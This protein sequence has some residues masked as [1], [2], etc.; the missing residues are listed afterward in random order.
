MSSHK[1]S[2]QTS[3]DE[4]DVKVFTNHPTLYHEDGN[5]ILSCGNTLF[6]VHRSVVAKHSPVLKRMLD[7]APPLVLRGCQHLELQDSAEDFEVLLGVLYDG[8]RIDFPNITAFNYPRVSS[9]L[10]ASTKYQIER[11]RA[12]LIACIQ[13]EWSSNLHVHDAKMQAIWSRRL[14]EFP[15]IVQNE[16]VMVNPNGNPGADAQPQDAPAHPA[17]VIRLLRD[18]GYHTADILFP[19]FYALSVET[20]QFG[21]PMLG[22]HVAPLQDADIE[23]LIVGIERLRAKHSSMSQFYPQLRLPPG[24]DQQCWPGIQIFWAI[25]GPNILLSPK[26]A[27]WPIEAWRLFTAHFNTPVYQKQY[28]FCSACATVLIGILEHRR[29]AMWNDLPAYFE[30]R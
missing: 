26:A 16:Q 9:L 18:C 8:L 27:R 22:T 4:T 28:S 7:D 1:R 21:T 17:A 2:R 6:C 25:I 13:R 19:L 24:H 23:R 3:E 10:R 15:T 14:A 11:A 12:D 30:L 20:S 29:T 5:V